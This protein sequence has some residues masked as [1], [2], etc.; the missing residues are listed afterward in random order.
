MR[1]LRMH[2]VLRMPGALRVPRALCPPWALR[3]PWVLPVLR[4][5]CVPGVKSLK[6]RLTLGSSLIAL[7]VL[8][9]VYLT[10]SQTARNVAATEARKRAEEVVR[11]FSEAIAEPLAAND[12]LQVQLLARAFQKNGVHSI[13]VTS[14]DGERLYPAP[15]DPQVDELRAAPAF[16]A[17]SGEGSL[18]TARLDGKLYL[19]AAKAISFA[20]SP[21]GTIHL[22]IDKSDLEESMRRASAPFFLVFSLGFAALIL[23]GSINLHR[24]FRALKKLSSAARR[25]GAGDLSARVPVSGADEMAE[26]STAFNLMVDGLLDARKQA[27]EKQLETIHAMINTVEAK[28]RY[29]AGHCLR[30]AGYAKEIVAACEGLS[31]D[32]AFV[33][34]TAALL[35]DVGKIGIPD[36]VLLKEGALSPEEHEVIRSHV[37]VGEEILS[38]MD[39]MRQI[40]RAIRHHHERWDGLG[41][42]EGLRGA[43]IPFASRVVGAADAIDAML[44]DRPYRRALSVEAAIQALEEGRGRQFDPMVVDLA[45][46]F[47]RRKQHEA[48]R[49]LGGSSVPAPAPE[50]ELQPA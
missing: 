19:H 47:L 29:T 40:A 46:E 28:D 16:Q 27:L 20:G 11:Y 37:V 33:I 49:V 42:P 13:L 25:I 8:A 22:W 4:V 32:E 15:A 45:V 7:G 9:V 30:V 44:T 23:L 10:V 50:P 12:R 24:H 43:A 39:S 1:W 48:V 17:A 18:G 35:H 34:Q 14:G 21:A 26:F 31:S 3:A 41:Y 36:K 6:A 38:H 2:W 5:L